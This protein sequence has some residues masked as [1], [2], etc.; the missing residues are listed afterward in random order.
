MEAK[1]IFIPA[2]ALIDLWAAMAEWLFV[3]GVYWIEA[4]QRQNQYGTLLHG[5]EP[6]LSS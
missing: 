1:Q 4:T 3:P 2:M 6:V 5:L